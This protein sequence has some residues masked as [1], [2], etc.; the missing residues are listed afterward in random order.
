M[1]KYTT[2]PPHLSLPSCLPRRTN[3]ATERNHGKSHGANSNVGLSCRYGIGGVD[4]ID[5][6]NSINTIDDFGFSLGRR[7]ETASLERKTHLISQP[8]VCRP[9]QAVVV[10]NQAFVG[11]LVPVWCQRGG[12]GTSLL[13]WV[14]LL[15]LLLAMDGRGVGRLRSTRSRLMTDGSVF[16]GGGEEQT[17]S[18]RDEMSGSLRVNV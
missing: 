1:S 9:Q 11:A 3:A 16:V 14:L 5:G 12:K 6:I 2:S 13:D 4:G 10:P 7:E 15:L 17:R 18:R 8:G